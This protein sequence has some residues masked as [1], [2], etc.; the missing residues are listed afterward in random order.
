M[1]KTTVKTKFQGLV[2]VHEKYV[3]SLKD[4]KTVLIEH[5]GQI[6]T[7]SP[8]RYKAYP[9]KQSGESFTEQYGSQRGKQYFLYGFKFEPDQDQAAAKRNAKRGTQELLSQCPYCNAVEVTLPKDRTGYQ[10]SIAVFNHL[11]K[12]RCFTCQ[13]KHD[14]NNQR[15]SNS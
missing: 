13:K 8:D 12:K 11:P 15:N 1:I 7:I 3:N 9:P 4:G 2:W 5:N 6:M 14:G 10:N